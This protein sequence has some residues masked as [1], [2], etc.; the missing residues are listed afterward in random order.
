M[1]YDEARDRVV[2]FG[3]VGLSGFVADTWEFDGQS[4]RDRTP[5]NAPPGRVWAAMAYDS[6]RG[7]TVMFGGDRF[8]YF[9]DTW[10]WDGNQWTRVQTP[11]SPPARSA[12][13][14]VYDRAR[15]CVVLFGGTSGP[16]LGDTWEYDGI[17]WRRRAPAAAPP[18]R[19]QFAMA[20]DEARAET[21]VFG[22][23]TVGGPCLADTW[24][25]DGAT[26]TR[27]AST[28]PSPRADFSMTYDRARQRVVLFGGGTCTPAGLRR[29]TWDFDGISWNE[30]L[31]GQGSAAVVAGLVYDTAR[32]R[33]VLFGGDFGPAPSD[34]TWTL[35][36]VNPSVSTPFGPVCPGFDR[37]PVL[38]SSLAWI[39]DLLAV[40]LAGLSTTVP[41]V[42]ALG[43][44]NTRIGS[45]SLPLELGFAGMPGCWL[46]TSAEAAVPM[47]SV[48]GA[49]Q[50]SVLIP[51][52]PALL[53]TTLYLQGLIPGAATVSNGLAVI[54]GAR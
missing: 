50:F 25:W 27:L 2:L 30:R 26:W 40:D 47:A 42:L 34:E 36:P 24:T 41:A 21:V 18:P 43:R 4:W 51:D 37:T 10:E 23:L 44:F 17:D 28:V 8:G 52:D 29:D 39:G 45:R 13:G 9:S 33:C 22:G 31:V 38:S 46:L 6:H 3:G 16:S 48:A 32:R 49:A 12:H 11:T 35:A 19:Q 20:F 1:A 15:R 14:M 53:G 5:A 7:R 54:V